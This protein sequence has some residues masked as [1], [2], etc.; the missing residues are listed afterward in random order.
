VGSPRIDL[1]DPASFAHGQPHETFRWLREHAPVYRHA[2]PNGR[3]FY[4]VTRYDD[5]KAVGR[6]AAT[7]SS[8]PTIMIADPEQGGL[9]LPDRQMMLMMDPPMHGK[10]RRLLSARFTPRA[11]E[12]LRPRIEQLSRQIVDAVIER[13]ECD[14]VEDIAGELPSF[15]TA[16]L[17][18]L[19]LE[20]GRRLYQ[21]TET[22][23]SAPEAVPP[24][25]QAAAVL[26]MFQYG[27]SVMEQKRKNPGDDLSSLLI[28][29]HVGDR[30]L[31]AID[32]NLMFM[33]IVDAGGD[34]TR[35]LVAGGMQALFDHP[36]ERRRLQ[37]GLDGLLESA[38]EEMLRF[39]SPVVYMR[40]TV[41]KETWLRDVKLAPGDKVVM[42][43]GSANR[44]PS[45]FADAE[46]FDVAREPNEHVAFGGG[47]PHYCLGS[48]VARIEIQAMLRE[49]LTRLPDIEPTAPAEWL[50]SVFISG[51]KR[52]PVRFTPGRRLGGARA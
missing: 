40:R 12:R 46:R 13:G 19:P 38:G 17:L 49:I 7:Y 1:L 43:Y 34:T 27:S 33:L 6:D 16:E 26:E 24:G 18:G 35:N 5:V 30:E 14:L 15:V 21:L 52:M 39:V 41:Q 22:I 28:G 51:P 47:G 48:H 29:A 44:D 37:A 42:Y 36:D 45:V 25:A 2:E 8:V 9:Q 4:A 10:F 3:G 32:F 11:V 23:H 31:D 50:P 20:D